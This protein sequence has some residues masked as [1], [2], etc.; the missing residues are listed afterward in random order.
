MLMSTADEIRIGRQSDREIVRAYGLYE[1][2]KLQGYVA[3]V[4]QKLAKVSH[5]PDLPFTFRI[6]DSPVVNAFAIPGGFVYV[7]RGILGYIN[8]EAELA[9]VLGH[10]IGH[11]TAR[12]SAR[13]YTKAQLAALGLEVGKMVS[14]RFRRYAGLAEV[15]V[16]LLFLKFSRDDERQADELG[17][18]YSSKGGYDA[19]HMSKF[20]VTLSRMHGGGG[21]ALPEWFSTHP[22]PG[23]RVRATRY[24]AEKWQRENPGLQLKVNR[25]RYLSF[26]DGLIF[27]EDPRQGYVKDGVFYHPILRFQFP[28]P[29]GWKL[30]NMATKVQMLSPKGDAAI[31]LTLAEGNDPYL[32]ARRFANSAGILV[33]AG[34]RTSV[35]GF[36]AYWIRSTV[37][38]GGNIMEVLS[39]FIAMGNRI[40][41]F[42]GFCAPE[43]FGVYKG[44][45]VAT[46][47]R[48]RNLDDP[49]LID[50]KPTR[51]KIVEV[52]S[53]G[54][55]RS[56]LRGF[57]VP[58]DELEEVA[59]IN[60]MELDE[61]LKPG[62]KIKVLVNP[63]SPH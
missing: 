27:G 28:V 21:G 9:G 42:H 20:F 16:G 19:T 26:I 4:G 3:E 53:G 55:L 43:S 48:F 23:D 38:T 13:R 15:G 18:E 30:T 58:E 1:D 41:A 5:R 31:L 17:V 12:H 44:V 39:Y 7:T 25:E 59:L 14:E 8:S 22:D 49:A 11:I 57:G 60:G 47:S 56:A 29:A 37:E 34:G 63:T 50:V 33:K 40:H 45:F 10:E 32:A 35:G 54:T 24:L 61:R 51:I 52:S 62:E 2:E 46:M 36:P 6:L